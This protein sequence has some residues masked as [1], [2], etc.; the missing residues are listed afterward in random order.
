MRSKQTA[1]EVIF[2]LNEKENCNIV[3]KI[4]AKGKLTMKK[5]LLIILLTLILALTCLTGCGAPKEP[6]TMTVS[7]ML[8]AV[9][10]DNGGE[11]VFYE[12]DKDQIGKDSGVTIC[13]YDGTQIESSPHNVRD[14]SGNTNRILLGDIAQDTYL[15]S[16]CEPW[17]NYLGNAEIRLITDSTGNNV[18]YEAIYHIGSSGTEKEAITFGEFDRVQIYDKTFMVFKHT[19]YNGAY[20]VYE[21]TYTIIPDTESTKDM[22]IV[23]DKIGTAGIVVD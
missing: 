23:F 12:Y 17:T 4:Y 2:F 1:H 8:N 13:Y 20:Q 18:E 11:M 10:A 21:N 14:S 5:N 9:L 15:A 22:T 7:E 6:N 19:W 3:I 16:E